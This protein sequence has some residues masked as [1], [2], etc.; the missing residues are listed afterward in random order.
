MLETREKT[1][2]R[3]T[4]AN[5][6]RLL[7]W[8]RTLVATH[9]DQPT[10]H[11]YLILADT[12]DRPLHGGDS[13]RSRSATVFRVGLRDHGIVELENRHIYIYIYISEKIA[14]RALS[15]ALYSPLDIVPIRA[16]L[17]MLES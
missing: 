1:G 3:I 13:S 2:H 11:R 16:G 14:T 9:D 15:R 4:Q 7:R 6:Q 17:L 5:G 10:Q 8:R 12:T